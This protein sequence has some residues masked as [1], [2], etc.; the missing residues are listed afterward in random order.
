VPGGAAPADVS[1]VATLQHPGNPDLAVAANVAALG[2]DPQVLLL[3]ASHPLQRATPEAGWVAA[4]IDA[5]TGL[6]PGWFLPQSTLDMWTLAAGRVTPYLRA[7]PSI[8]GLQ[9]RPSFFADM[10]DALVHLG[11]LSLAKPHK[12]GKWIVELARAG[13]ECGT[14]P[15]VLLVDTAFFNAQPRATGGAAIAAHDYMYLVGGDLLFSDN[16]SDTFAA[17]YLVKGASPRNLRAERDSARDPFCRFFATLCSVSSNR[18]KFFEDA[19]ADANTPADEITEYV[20]STWMLL[21]K[22]GYPFC[23]GARFS[24]R[25][26]EVEKASRMA[27][28]TA[29]QKQIVFTELFPTRLDEFVR[30]RKC[31]DTGSHIQDWGKSIE[32]FMHLAEIFFPGSMWANFTMVSAVEQDCPCGGDLGTVHPG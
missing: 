4:P 29:E 30:V 23:F 19:L 17:A 6:S 26:M 16:E 31:V 11:R 18:S 10:L 28:G 21:V 32:A 2:A 14:D 13:A 22:T 24:Q 7:V 8:L 3:D 20:I 1:P 12:S 9:A 27:F 25:G 15:R 5:A